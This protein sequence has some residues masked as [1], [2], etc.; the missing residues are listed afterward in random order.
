M[1][2]EEKETKLLKSLWGFL[3][4]LAV[5]L[6][7]A[8]L[9]TMWFVNQEKKIRL[10]EARKA[11][12]KEAVPPVRVII[13]TLE[14]T[15]LADKLDL[16]AEVESFENLWVKTE[17]SGQVVRVPVKEGQTIEKGQVLVE[18]DDRDYRLRL[19]RIQANHKLATLDHERVVELA[20]KK[21]TAETEL[22]KIDAQLKDLSAQLKEAQ[23]ALSRT[24][25]RAPISG[26]LNEIEAKIGDWLGV[27]KPVAQI[28]QLEAVKVTVGVPESDVSAVLDLN[29][30]DVVIEALGKRKV[31]GTK[32]FLSR[33]PNTF[34]RLYDLELIV[35][36]PDGRILPGMFARV[37][38]VKEVFDEALI[39]PIYAVLTQGDER[40]VYV[41]EDNKAEKRHVELGIL[42]GWQIQVT[43]GLKPGDQV[44][45]DG[46]RL[47]DDGQT[48]EV[49]RNVRDV[50]E[51][52]GS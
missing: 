12:I 42:S 45:V 10:E 41:V 48:V 37:E 23:L 32:I 11:A 25:I 39:I 17:V 27:D 50:R 46:H 21:I 14:P 5:L 7:C 43:S 13:L 4:W 49:L 51:I 16:P 44:I 40:F 31:T 20:R 22:D 2:M 52:I 38:L 3:P 9:A 29:E 33:Q 1:K 24:K 35:Q 36:N 28:L 8:L 6:L 19:E 18:L 15:R 26:R 30:A 47:L 34:A